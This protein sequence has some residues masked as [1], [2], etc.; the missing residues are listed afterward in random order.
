MVCSQ[1]LITSFQL[2]VPV[3]WITELYDLWFIFVETGCEL[4]GALF[5]AGFEFNLSDLYKGGWN[6]CRFHKLLAKMKVWILITAGILTN[7]D[8]DYLMVHMY[9]VGHIIFGHLLIQDMTPYSVLSFLVTWGRLELLLSLGLHWL[10]T[11]IINALILMIN[12]LSLSS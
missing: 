6:I 8:I 9:G 11:V 12:Y 4:N 10:K 5:S 1:I 3:L 7:W 2:L